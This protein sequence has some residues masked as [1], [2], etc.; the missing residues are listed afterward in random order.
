MML[1]EYQTVL[2]LGLDHFSFAKP[3]AL[4]M[5]G[6]IDEALE[7]VRRNEPPANIPIARLY[8]GSF[9]KLLEG[10]GAGSVSTMEE[11]LASTFRDPE[12]WYYMARQFGYLREPERAMRTL[13]KAIDLGFFCYPAMVRDP[14][15]DSLRD[16]PQFNEILAK[17]QAQHQRAFDAFTAEGGEALLGVREL[18]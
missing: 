18:A 2:E 14:W 8:M 4:T 10:D 11:L 15:F 12:G 3:L 9:R 6:R 16:I 7:I 13:S 5:L 1:G 17:A